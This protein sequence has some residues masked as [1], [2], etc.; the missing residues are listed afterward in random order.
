M[1]ARLGRKPERTRMIAHRLK[2]GSRWPCKRRKRPTCSNP[3]GHMPSNKLPP[4]VTKSII[5]SAMPILSAPS[6]ELG[7]TSR[8]PLAVSPY[9]TSNRNGARSRSG[10]RCKHSQRPCLLSK[11]PA[12]LITCRTGS[13]LSRDRPMMPISPLSAVAVSHPSAFLQ[14]ESES[15]RDG[16][17]LRV[18]Q[19]HLQSSKRYSISF[20]FLLPTPTTQV[21]CAHPQRVCAH[22]LSSADRLLGRRSQYHVLRHHISP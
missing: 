13:S 17:Y 10:M 6:C 2:R 16:K 3:H 8:S 1:A 11:T 19:S 14:A 7:C 21:A 22:M 15:D 12:S 18:S 4:A 5:L 9:H 20:Y